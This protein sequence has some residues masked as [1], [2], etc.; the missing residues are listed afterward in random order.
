MEYVFEEYIERIDFKNGGSMLARIKIN[1]KWCFVDMRLK[2]FR[3]V[4]DYSDSMR[5]EEM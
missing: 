2:E 4:D 3:N 5:F 1:G